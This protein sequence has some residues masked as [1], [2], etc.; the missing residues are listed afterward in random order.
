MVLELRTLRPDLAFRG[1]GGVRMA[2]AGVE[3]VARTDRIGA[4][5]FLEL[6]PHLIHLR[7]LHKKLLRMAVGADLVVLVDYAGFNLRLARSLRRCAPSSRRPGVLYY[8]PPKVWAWGRERVEELRKLADKVAAILPFE[9]AYLRRAGI[10]AVYVGHPLLDGPDTSLGSEGGT[11]GSA[12]GGRR[13]NQRGIDYPVLALL[14][15]SRPEELRMHLPIFL[16]TAFL[17]RRL[18][19]ELQIGIGK[20]EAIPLSTYR[21]GWRRWRAR[22]GSRAEAPFVVGDVGTLLRQASAG[23]VKSGTITLECALAGLPH[24]VAYR[25][26][27]LSWSFVRRRLTVEHVSLPNLLLAREAVP[28]LLQNQA[29]P[30]ALADAAYPLLADEA[31]GSVQ[32]K[33]FREIRLRLE[34]PHGAGGASRRV[35][36]MAAAMLR[37]R[38]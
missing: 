16:S 1:A 3:L 10:D 18:M 2:S 5:G 14:P 20:T 34:S 9:E 32:R 8:V 13:P 6:A 36:E 19:P 7:E 15:G 35:A 12:P 28:E 37:S 24:V 31:P 4:A 21:D 33:R 26:N 27:P 25:M 29:T 23:I 22:T 17:L 11:A 30:E 38:K